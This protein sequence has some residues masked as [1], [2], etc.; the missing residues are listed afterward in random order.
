M[1][2]AINYSNWCILRDYAPLLIDQAKALY[3]N[4]N[5]LDV[6]VKNNV[7]A[8]DSTVIALCLN[9]FSWAKLRKTKAA[10]K[11]H[12]ILDLKTSIPDFIHVTDT[13]VHDV[14]ILDLID[15]QTGSYYIMDRG[16]LDFKRFHK[17]NFISA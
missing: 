16:Y 17:I 12:T 14:N 9:V 8:I 15:F 5:Q 6:D 10:V 13:L 2:K 11:I 3:I 4:N 7:F 1:S